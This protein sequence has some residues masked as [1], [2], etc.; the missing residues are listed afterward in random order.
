MIYDYTHAIYRCEK[1]NDRVA[2]MAT[3]CETC[4]VNVKGD[5][6]P[7][8]NLVKTEFCDRRDKEIHT[9]DI[10]RY[11]VGGYIKEVDSSSNGSKVFYLYLEV[12]KE[13]K[14]VL[15]KIIF[16]DQQG[17][18]MRMGYDV[19]ALMEVPFSECVIIGNARY[20]PLCWK[21]DVRKHEV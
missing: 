10:I 4:G 11:P 21:E 1:C 18:L 3:Y 20:N 6:F 5:V 16:F 12:V 19:G 14:K 2:A 13:K 7:D 17:C 15:C 9:H 8:L